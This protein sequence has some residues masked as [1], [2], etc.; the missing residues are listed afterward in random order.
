MTFT[1][2]LVESSN[3][4]TIMAAA[5]GS[6]AA[7]L[8][9]MLAPLRHRRRRP[10][11][12]CRARA[13]ASC[14]TPKDEWSGTDYGTHADRPGLLRQRRADGLGLRDRRQRRRPGARRPIVK[15]TADEDGT[16][17]PAAQAET[18]A[19]ASPE[20]AA[21]LR[22]DARGRHQ[23]GR[24]RAAARPSRATASPARPAPPSASSTAATTAATPRQ[25]RRLRPGRRAAAGRLGRRSRPRKNGYYG[26]AVAGPVFRDIMSLR[27]AQ[28]A[29][30]ADRRRRRRNAAACRADDPPVACR[31][32]PR[33]LTARPAP[34]RPAQPRRPAADRPAGRASPALRP[35]RPGRRRRASPAARSTRAPCSPATS[36]PRCP[37]PAP[38]APTSPR[39]PPRP[40]AAAVLTD[41][42]RR[43]PL[44]R[45]TACPVLV[46][47]DPRAVLGAVGRAGSTTTRRRDLLRARRHRHQRQDHDGV[48]ARGRAA[49]RRPRAPGCSARS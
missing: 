46:A 9:E 48:P 44:P 4:G 23:R 28:H 22:G 40:G 29:G 6:A 16:V 38:T 2:V 7:K 41:A 35:D 45:R 49:R 13:A 32:C 34:L 18:A 42:G 17:V 20:V 12:A 43:R 3:V 47:D 15:A 30:P 19:G 1:G 31:P 14:A 5:E 10:A 37:A 33:P 21:Q 26:G 24:H 8:H 39:R 36:T 11:S 27:A 25:L